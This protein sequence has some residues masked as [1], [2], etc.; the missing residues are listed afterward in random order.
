YEI[1]RARP[2]DA[3]GIVGLMQ[4]TFRNYGTFDVAIAMPAMIEDNSPTAPIVY[5]ATRKENTDVIATG[6]VEKSAF[7]FGEFTDLAVD[8]LFCRN[9]GLATALGYRVMQEARQKGMRHYWTDSVPYTTISKVIKKMGVRLSGIHENQVRINT[10]QLYEIIKRDPDS[11]DLIVGT[12][13][14]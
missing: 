2:D 6:T 1:R 7:G 14:L 3:Q 9:N 11:M 5:V 8:A 4:R 12:G 13:E 10:H